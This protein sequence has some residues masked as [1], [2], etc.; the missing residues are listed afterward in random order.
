MLREEGVAWE[1]RKTWEVKRH[2][3]QFMSLP[4]ILREKYFQVT[5]GSGLLSY[6][7]AQSMEELVPSPQWR[8]LLKA[9][10]PLLE[11]LKELRKGG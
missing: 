1:G 3:P 2:I 11:I 8:Q 6:P 9:Q 10:G 5:G 4:P 7:P